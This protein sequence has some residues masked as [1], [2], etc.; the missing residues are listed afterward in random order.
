MALAAG[1]SVVLEPSEKSPLTAPRVAR[2]AFAAGIPAGVFNVVPNGAEPGR[3]LGCIAT[4][5]ASRSRDRHAP[6]SRSWRAPRSQ[7]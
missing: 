4:S 2:L 3:A 7:T 6:G 5:T 1:N